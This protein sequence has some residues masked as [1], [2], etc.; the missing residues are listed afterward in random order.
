MIFCDIEK[1]FDSV[2]WD[3]LLAAMKATNVG[4]GYRKWIEM[5]YS[6]DAPPRRR[7]RANGDKGEWFGL[8]SGVAQGC[9]LSPLLFIFT[10]SLRHLLGLADLIRSSIQPQ[11]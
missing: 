1:A 10:V 2:S 8:Q 7:V 3:Y 9:P 4:P 6:L 5:M 11:V